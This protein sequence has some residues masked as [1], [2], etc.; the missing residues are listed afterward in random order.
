MPLDAAQYREVFDRVHDIVYVRDLDGVIIDINEA[1]A[2]FF[3]RAKEELIGQTLHRSSDDE[4][5]RSLRATNDLLLLQGVDRSTVELCNGAGETRIVEA[6]TA[7]MRDDRGEARGAYGVMRD[8]TDAVVLQ[9][10]LAAANER[11]KQELEQARLVQQALLP[12]HVPELPHLD[13]AVR[14]RSA[15]EVGGDY[16]DFAVG[17]DGTLTIA[18]GDVIGHGFRAGIYGATAKSY[19]QTLSYAPP[20]EILET[21]S[22][23]FRNLGIPSLYMCLM[24]VRIRERQASIVG[25]GM[26]AFFV[27]HR[28]GGVDRVEVAGTPL[29]AQRKPEFEGR[30][31][32][33]DAGTAML[34]CS[35]G[36]AELC[37]EEQPERGEAAIRTCF[38]EV[39]D[40][41]AEQTLARVLDC[42][43]SRSAGRPPADDVTIM[44]IRAT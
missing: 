31:I 2:R 9:R 12:Q 36:L 15:S 7:L 30:D 13:I 6:M 25:A 22:A 11:Q 26:P 43:D 39:A 14:M 37:D 34:L 17:A 19:F 28:D 35:D 27:R 4:Q 5:A 21:M 24:L 38:S 10:S 41:R 20:R 44:V 42:A 18:M 29:G 3:G 8:V 33:F 16:Y 40:E 32:E 23:A 1:G